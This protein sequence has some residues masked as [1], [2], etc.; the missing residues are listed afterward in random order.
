M[1]EDDALQKNDRQLE[2]IDDQFNEALQALDEEKG[3]KLSEVWQEVKELHDANAG[4]RKNI[5]QN[6]V[7]LQSHYKDWI[8]TRKRIGRA[9]DAI[10][11]RHEKSKPEDMD[12][13]GYLDLLK[14]ASE[15]NEKS[16]RLIS[17]LNREIRASAKEVR[18]S[19]F[20]SRF[21]Y[22]AS[23]L[24][25]IMLM[26]YASISKRLQR[27][28]EA[29]DGMMRDMREAAKSFAIQAAHEVDFEADEE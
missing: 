19:E 6:Q 28:P 5:Q 7:V 9:I 20:Q 29:R 11:K 14:Q 8:A 21:F 3:W 2:K 10:E 25:K 27:H 16:S 15:L 1:N 13:S 18:Q 24:Q 26:F 12:V 4:L 23:V 22:H 17:S